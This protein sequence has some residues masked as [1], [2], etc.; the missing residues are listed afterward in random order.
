MNRQ[1]ETT[2]FT[3]FAH[4]IAS[5]AAANA[6][7]TE[8]SSQPSANAAALF[9]FN[10]NTVSFDEL[11]QLG[12]SPRTA[13]TLIHY[14]EKGGQ[15][16]KP[17]DF[18]KVYGIKAD[19][20]ARLEP[21]IALENDGNSERN[22]SN[23]FQNDGSKFSSKFD[24]KT[25]QYQPPR[26]IVLKPFDPNTAT[27][28]DLLALGL[29][30]KTVKNLIKYREKGGHFWKKEDLKK[31]YDFSDIDFLRISSF[32]QIADNQALGK[33]NSGNNPNLTNEKKPENQS[34]KTNNPI[35]LNG[36]TLEDWLQIRGIGRTFATRIIEQREKLGGFSSPEQLKEVF[37]LP[38]S[39]LRNIAP[40]LRLT[41]PI[42]RKIHVN[43]TTLNDLTHP[44][45]TRKQAEAIVRYR[46]NHG[47]FQ[48]LEDLRKTGVLP[49]GTLE[50]L[51]T[52][53]AFD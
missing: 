3:Q 22:F 42:Y 23:S 33:V 49:D 32:V 29:E 26:D 52:Y 5:F 30:E 2:D 39:T 35:D 8:G 24:S 19:D 53:I 43:K 46:T 14:R 7:D 41:T 47:A 13:T 44:Y 18:K 10:P 38:D 6:T 48:T 21:Y 25:P 37:G 50:K 34:I 28:T 17:E 27:E 45:L 12:I 15:F 36:A 1:A 40:Y 20:Y 4:Q 16:R 9:S 51:K 31:L 11:V